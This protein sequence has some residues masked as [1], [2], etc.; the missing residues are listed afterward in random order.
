M[1]SKDSG[2][3]KQENPIDSETVNVEFLILGL[4]NPDPKVREFSAEQLGNIGDKRATNALLNSM[5]NDKE[6]IVRVV[7]ACALEKIGDKAVVDPLLEALKSED[8]LIRSIAPIPLVNFPDDNVVEALI[9]ALDDYDG[10]RYNAADALGEIGDERAVEPLI[11]A[12]E[13]A[14]EHSFEKN[15]AVNLDP[16]NY[17]SPL[18][19]IN[20][21]EAKEALT[22]IMENPKYKIFEIFIEKAIKK[23]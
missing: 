11:E 6:N 17:L 14:M 21:A 1:S 22:T 15:I 13:D 5:I 12:M 4:K 7:S 10:A 16:I 3:G 2:Q 18:A 8:K 23:P 19:K 20:N 9:G